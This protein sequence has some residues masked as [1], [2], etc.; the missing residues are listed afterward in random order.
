MMHYHF[1]CLF[2]LQSAELLLQIAMTDPDDVVREVALTSY[3]NHKH[4]VNLQ[5]YE[6]KPGM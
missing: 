6:I 1:V 3:Q 5:P 2:C 4:G